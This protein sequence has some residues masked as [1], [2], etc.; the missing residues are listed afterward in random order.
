[1]K[2]IKNIVKILLIYLQNVKFWF[3]GDS[4]RYNKNSVQFCNFS[5]VLL[6]LKNVKTKILKLYISHTLYFYPKS[7]RLK[8]NNHAKTKEEVDKQLETQFCNHGKS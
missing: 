1:M 2:I 5:L 6:F 4:T 7:Q 3:L 8:Q